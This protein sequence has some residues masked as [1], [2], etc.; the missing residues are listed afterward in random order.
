MF[1]RWGKY[2]LLGVLGT[3]LGSTAARADFYLHHWEDHYVGPRVADLDLTFGYYNSSSNFNSS[4]STLAPPQ[5][6]SYRRLYGDATAT[7]GIND[8][9]TLFGR[10]TWTAVHS[11]FGG[12]I[13]DS[14]GFEDQSVGIVMRLYEAPSKGF[15]ID[16]Q[17]QVDLPAYS[18]TQSLTE[19]LPYLGDGSTDFTG[20][21]FIR[22]P[23]IHSDN[24]TEFDI[25]GGAGYTYRTSNFSA[26]VPWA[27]GA[28]FF[29][30]KSPVGFNANIGV[31][32]IQ[33]LKT[34]PVNPLT[35]QRDS[36]G[37][38][39]SLFI[40]AVDP[41]LATVKAGI[42]YAF[43]MVSVS[44]GFAEDFY[45][46]SAPKGFTILGGV[47]LRLDRGEKTPAA[48]TRRQSGKGFVNYSME[49]HVKKAGGA[50]NQLRIDKGSQDNVATGQVFDIFELKGSEGSGLP[51]AR[52][53]VTGVAP[54]EAA[55]TVIE[56]YKEV[57]IEEGFIARRSVQ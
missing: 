21:P 25:F 53:R 38:G 49:A 2:A 31:Y 28:K 41:S 46:Q 10:L 52:A 17:A 47:S 14:Y 37:S 33:S 9:F 26:A 4:G 44:A 48:Q 13:G 32:G 23:V 35:G 1:G 55:L 56:Y 50:P 20:G 45:G 6:A 57:L 40:N 42:G 22:V 34:D 7:Y 27:A 16:F 54:E 5:L 19:K 30:E 18:N 43:E 8:R 12:T 24:D 29:P 51:V 3:T 36:N 11:E 39:G 15:T